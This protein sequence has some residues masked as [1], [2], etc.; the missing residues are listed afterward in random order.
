MDAPRISAPPHPSA[1]LPVH[2]PP[3][4]APRFVEDESM[5]DATVARPAFVHKPSVEALAGP[6]LTPVGRDA[7]RSETTDVDVLVDTSK[8]L[9]SN[10]HRETRPI[11][12]SVRFNPVLTSRRRQV[13]PSAELALDAGSPVEP[14]V[15][16][17]TIGRVDVHSA[18]PSPSSAR[19]SAAPPALSLDDYLKRASGRS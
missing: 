11:H 4:P 9:A 10:A 12:A 16:R 13:P 19:P 6:T 18:E 8:T 17:V 3:A 14:A 7:R 1:E 5:V 2:A 15:I